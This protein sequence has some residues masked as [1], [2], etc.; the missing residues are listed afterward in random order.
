MYINQPER[1][2]T[3]CELPDQN[4]GSV[5]ITAHAVIMLIE[6]RLEG[7]GALVWKQRTGPLII[8]QRG[9]LIRGKT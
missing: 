6:T 7:T 8:P 9:N 4:Q 2:E 5:S 1:W 3:Q